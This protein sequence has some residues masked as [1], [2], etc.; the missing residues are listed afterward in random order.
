MIPILWSPSELATDLIVQIG[1][2]ALDVFT[3]Q[4]TRAV[5]DDERTLVQD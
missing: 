4:H 2:G 5:V 3:G 1:S